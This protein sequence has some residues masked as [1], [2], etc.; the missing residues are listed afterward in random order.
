MDDVVPLLSQ[1]EKGRS[2]EGGKK[3]Y[4][5]AQCAKCHRFAG[6]GGDTG[7]DITSVGNKFNPTYILE[8]LIHPSKAISD[9]YVTQVI[10]LE[11][12]EVITGRILED[13]GDTIKVRTD[14]FALKIKEIKKSEIEERTNSKVSEMP[15]GLINTLTKEELLD[16][17]A[18][19]R[20]AGN[21]DD[22]AFK[23]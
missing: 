11:S 8:S 4:A 10:S 2:F 16:L 6:Q 17:V 14:P 5:V 9:Q 19:L 1:V 18:Y 13:K 12:G 23:P 22:K 15:E 21:A 20:S 7:P 3:A